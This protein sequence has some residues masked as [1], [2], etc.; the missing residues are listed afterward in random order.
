MAEESVVETGEVESK[1]LSIV[2]QAKGIAI[3]DADSY[4]AAG[5]IW[6]GIRDMMNEISETF[7]PIIQQ[8]HKAHKMAIEKKNKFFIP[9]ENAAKAVKKLM[10]NYDQEQ[11]KKRLLEQRRL[12]EEARKKEEDM[13][14]EE[15]ILAEAMGDT[16]GAK[17]ILDE[18]VFVP[19]VVVAK[20]T[21]K[22]QGGPVSRTIY[23]FR[24][25]DASLIPRQFLIPDMVAIGG[26]VRSLKEKASIPGIEVYEDKV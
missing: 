8:Q 22:I 9:L 4:V 6:K 24:I 21:P 10:A 3:I 14:L 11:E 26:V 16:E 25:T 5:T 1:A 13:R 19:P 23:K 18:P 2:E 15:A 7:D 20:E 12:E 17:E